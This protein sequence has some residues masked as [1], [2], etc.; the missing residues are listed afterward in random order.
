[1]GITPAERVAIAG[2][3]LA[4]TRQRWGITETLL[5]SRCVKESQLSL[6]TSEAND[7]VAGRLPRSVAIGPIPGGCGT[8]STAE[9]V[10]DHYVPGQPRPGTDPLGREGW[11]QPD[12]WRRVV[13]HGILQSTFSGFWRRQIQSHRFRLC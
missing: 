5:M 2:I 8:C 11:P 10:A 3:R 1:M 9:V 6:G 12:P 4:I 7:G 13:Q